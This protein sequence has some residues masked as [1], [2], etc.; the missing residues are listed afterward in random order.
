MAPNKKFDLS[1]DKI[2]ILFIPKE[3]RKKYIFAVEIY[4]MFKNNCVRRKAGLT[5]F[6]V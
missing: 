2:K 6:Y 4:K 3:S 1:N 5:M